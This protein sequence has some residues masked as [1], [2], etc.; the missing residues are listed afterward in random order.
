MSALP[1]QLETEDV[2]TRAMCIGKLYALGLHE[3]ERRFVSRKT[4]ISFPAGITNYFIDTFNTKSNGIV[5]RAI[6]TTNL[7]STF[8]PSGPGV[9]K[10]AQFT[11]MTATEQE[12]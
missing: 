3:D 10:G 1:V 9:M 5:G 2:E 12:F 6:K 8:D 11:A 7:L 4:L